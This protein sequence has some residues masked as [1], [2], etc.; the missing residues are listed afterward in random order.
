MVDF[1]RFLYGKAHKVKCHKCGKEMLIPNMMSSE[2]RNE[3]LDPYCCAYTSFCVQW[4]VHHGW[5][6]RNLG[7]TD[8]HP[9]FC[10][11]CWE[12]GTPEYEAKDYGE[13]WCKQAQAW[14]EQ[15]K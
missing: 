11:D 4:L 2:T 14:V 7:V 1:K 3:V 6:V 13:Q 15:N 5:H 9:Y 10:P 12:E 8:S